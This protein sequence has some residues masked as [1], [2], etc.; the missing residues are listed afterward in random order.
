MKQLRLTPKYFFRQVLQILMGKGH[1]FDVQKK[2][3]CSCAVELRT[4]GVK[5]GVNLHTA[6]GSALV[7]Q[8]FFIIQI[9]NIPFVN[10]YVK[11]LNE[12]LIEYQ[13]FPASAFGKII[14]CPQ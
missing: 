3:S 14:G 9:R 5:K 13:G 2:S 6:L 10:L 11:T 1:K 12:C 8:V 4:G 7:P